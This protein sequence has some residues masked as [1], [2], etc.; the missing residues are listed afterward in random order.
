MYTI[1]SEYVSKVAPGNKLAYSIICLAQS[2]P[3]LILLL[4][5]T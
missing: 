1:V 3:Q 4:K 2:V 5:P